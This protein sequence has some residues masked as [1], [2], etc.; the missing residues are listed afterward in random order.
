MAAVDV[1]LWDMKGRRLGTPLW[2]PLGGH[3]PKVRA[4]AGNIDLNFPVDQLLEGARKSVEAGFHSVK[5]RLGRPTLAD[6][7][8]T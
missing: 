6:A 8:S 1:A 5:M 4:Y 7:R 3:E 2:R